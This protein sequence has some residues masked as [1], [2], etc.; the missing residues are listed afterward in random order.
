MKRTVRV[1]NG[2]AFDPEE[3]LRQHGS[4][5][6]LFFPELLQAKFRVLKEVLEERHPN[7]VVAYSVKTN[8]L[9]A[10]V[11][12]AV[13]CGAALEIVAGLE[14][15]LVERLGL[16]SPATIVNGPLKT[17]DELRRIVRHGCR[18]NVDTM[19][20][21]EALERIAAET[22]H[23]VR[24]GLRVASRRRQGAPDRFGFDADGLLR[25][26]QQV[27]TSMPHLKI[28]GLH[29]HGG[30]NI[31][32]TTFYRQ[33]ACLLCRLALQL[34]DAQLLDLSYLDLGGGFATAC[35]FRD[36][37]ESHLPS[38]VEYVDAIVGPIHESFGPRGPT[39]ILEPGRYLVDDAFVLLTTV[40][41]F[42]DADAH[43]V[44]V[45]AG[46]NVLPSARFRSHR[47]VCVS[48]E[49]P[50]ASPY[51][52]LG[53]LCMRSDRLADAVM[54]PRLRY[55][56]VLAVSHAG[57]Y[58]ISQAW[59]FIRLLPAVVAVEGGTYVLARR[60]QTIN[61]FLSRDLE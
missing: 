10:V 35:P 27:G 11:R 28:V 6:F 36:R 4:P 45:D 53:P 22:E 7:H 30:T 32:D 8:Y 40:Q 43:E 24:I 46:V 29:V 15:E 19:S 59:N 41:R 47:I 58:S 25:V 1:W 23:V 39:L 31:T 14:L 50:A 33:A 5:L 13:D 44:I 56:D 17:D 37:I 2:P 48:Q 12:R 34:Q 54:L 16:I 42:R 9:P 26:A 55:G 3:L 21:L 51:A 57:A 20:E 61:D 49:A 52:I 60:R 18:L 38:A